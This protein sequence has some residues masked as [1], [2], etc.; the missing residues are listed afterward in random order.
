MGFVNTSRP[1]KRAGILVTQ[2][3]INKKNAAEILGFCSVLLLKFDFKSLDLTF[4]S[5]IT[6]YI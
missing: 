2:N 6:E 4:P 3:V 1:C 5:V